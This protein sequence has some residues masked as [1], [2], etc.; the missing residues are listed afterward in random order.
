LS[1]LQN[2]SFGFDKNQFF[3]KTEGQFNFEISE[4]VFKADLIINSPILKIGKEEAWENILKVLK[5][6]NYLGLKYVFSKQ[7]IRENLDKVL[8]SFLTIAEAEVVQKPDKFTAFLGIILAGFNSLNLERVFAEVSMNKDL[9]EYLKNV[10]IEEIPI[11]G[12][13][14]EEVQLTLY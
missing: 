4:E 6:E 3:E 8:P 10:K 14:I 13:Q 11:I 5:K 12:R 1:E 2:C 9:P 7:E